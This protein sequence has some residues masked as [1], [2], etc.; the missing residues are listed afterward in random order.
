M[1]G[2]KGE[3]SGGEKEWLCKSGKEIL[4][5]S[6]G[7]KNR[8]SEKHRRFFFHWLEV[9]WPLNYL[10]DNGAFHYFCRGREFT[11]L[12]G[13]G[14]LQIALDFFLFLW[15]AIENGIA[16]YRVG[17]CNMVSSYFSRIHKRQSYNCTDTWVNPLVA[18]TL[19]RKIDAAIAV[20]NH[21][22]PP[23]SSFVAMIIIMI[24]MWLAWVPTS[25]WMIGVWFKARSASAF[26]ATDVVT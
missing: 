5:G 4:T 17:S 6:S 21:F 19:Q 18:T 25:D 9:I 26:S 3:Q 22:F 14:I 24:V 2:L 1:K 8:G 16:I 7:E 13:A 12:F 11:L 20:V 23:W 10:S 15:T